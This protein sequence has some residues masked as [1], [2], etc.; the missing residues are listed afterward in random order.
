MKKRGLA[1]AQLHL[2]HPEGSFE[3]LTTLPYL[4]KHDYQLT[5][6]ANSRQEIARETN[7]TICTACGEWSMAMQGVESPLETCMSA[8]FGDEI[9]FSFNEQKDF[10][11]HGLSI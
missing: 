6:T 10:P 8:R 5:D 4:V 11:G 9:S 2:Q 3:I 7:G 1:R